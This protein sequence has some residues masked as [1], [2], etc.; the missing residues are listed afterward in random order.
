[1]YA[2]L[3]ISFLFPLYN[4]FIFFFFHLCV[5]SLS[6]HSSSFLVHIYTHV[7]HT[8][9]ANNTPTQHIHPPTYSTDLLTQHPPPLFPSLPFPIPSRLLRSPTQCLWAP[10]SAG[11]W[12]GSGCC[13]TMRS[14]CPCPSPPP[15]TLH[16]QALVMTGL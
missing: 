6:S 1:M 2:L 3:A 4:L 10:R 7:M 9:I 14:L 12:R 13:S 16:P 11:V 15:T 8:P 5:V